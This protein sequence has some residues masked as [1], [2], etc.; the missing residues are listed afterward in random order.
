M[1]CISHSL[2]EAFV[3]SAALSEAPARR[4]YFCQTNYLNICRTDLNEI[5][6]IGRNFAADERPEVIFSDPQERCRG[7]QCE[8]VGISGTRFYRAMLS[9]RGTSPVSVCPCLSVTSRSF[10]ETDER[11]GLVFFGT[12]AL[13]DLSYTVF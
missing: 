8:T 1:H 11:I 13:F 2:H 6:R 7:N 4:A 9:I 12:G 5:C 3:S 10:V